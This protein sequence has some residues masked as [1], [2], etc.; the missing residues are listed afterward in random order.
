LGTIYCQLILVLD[1]VIARK[2]TSPLLSC[3]VDIRV[4]QKISL[5]SVDLF[6]SPYISCSHAHKFYGQTIPGVDGFGD[7]T[8]VRGLSRM[9]SFQ[10]YLL[11]RVWQHASVLCI[12]KIADNFVSTQVI[13]SVNR[14]DV[15]IRKELFSNILVKT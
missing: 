3:L 10:S 12:A 7:S 13:D 1:C 14:C 5:K 4:V 2:K 11:L 8:P 6:L 15:D 9:V